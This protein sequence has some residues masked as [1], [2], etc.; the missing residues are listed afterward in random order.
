M[1]SYKEFMEGFVHPNHKKL[2]ANNNLAKGNL[3]K[4]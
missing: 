3:E 1:K 2:D 4:F